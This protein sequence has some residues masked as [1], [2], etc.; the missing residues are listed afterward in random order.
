ME[1]AVTV[2]SA[3]GTA[4]QGVSNDALSMIQTVLPYG[5]AIFGAIVLIKVAKRVFNK[6][7]G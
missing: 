3:L 7:T 6:I 2:S 1:P 4:L 5:I